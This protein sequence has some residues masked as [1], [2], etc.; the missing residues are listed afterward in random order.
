M[1][2]IE[3]HQAIGHSINGEDDHWSVHCPMCEREFEYTGYFDEE[4]KTECQCG[5]VFRTTQVWINDDE[6][7]GRK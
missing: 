5:C 7:V 6:F 2:E 4:D 1:K 3:I